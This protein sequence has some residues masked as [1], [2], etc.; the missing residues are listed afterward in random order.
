MKPIG[1]V[2]VGGDDGLALHDNLTKEK[3]DEHGNINGCLSTYS[4]TPELS[5]V[6]RRDATR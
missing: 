6:Q 1:Y 5:D 4:V 3:Q 2:G